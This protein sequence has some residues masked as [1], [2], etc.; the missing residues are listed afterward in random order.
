MPPLM[1]LCTPHKVFLD[2]WIGEEVVH[3]IIIGLF[4]KTVPKAVPKAVP[5]TVEN[6]MSLAS[7][8]VR[9]QWLPD[10]ASPWSLAGSCLEQSWMEGAPVRPIASLCFFSPHLQNGFGFKG[11]KV[12]RVIKDPP[13]G[14][15]STM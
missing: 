2:L 15:G 10:R 14:Q 8:E 1:Y 13:C 11:T 3:H 6:F 5:K 7:G 12:H 4:G 9:G